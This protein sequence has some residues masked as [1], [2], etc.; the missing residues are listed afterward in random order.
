VYSANEF[1]T[2]VN[3]MKAYRFPE[4]DTPV[5]VGKDVAVIGGGNTAM[6]AVRTAKRLGADK[7]Y[8]IYRRS[9]DEMPARLE[10]IHHAEEEGIEFHLLTNPIR[11]LADA[12]N[13]VNGIECLRMELGEPDE[14]GRRKPIPIKGSEFVLPVQAVVEAVGQSPNPIVQS[15]TPGLNTGK[16]GVVVVDDVQMTSRPGVF[17][18]GD[19]A[20]GGATVILAMR[21]G[22]IAAEAIH[23]FLTSKGNGQ[24]AKA[25]A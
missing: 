8:L 15:T 20:R 5:H 21:D 24:A 3:L 9:R 4:Y 6:D 22:K 23:K 25:Q 2:R 19:L 14:S 18:G 16:R 12:N 10:E 13:W 1:L 7:A 17:A 11:I